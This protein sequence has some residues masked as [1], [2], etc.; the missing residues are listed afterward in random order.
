MSVNA[1]LDT[2]VWLWSLA[3]ESR[4]APSVRER[5]LADESRIWLSPVSL[6][7]ALVLADRGRVDFGMPLERWI[8][9]ATADVG[10]REAPLTFE[11]AA[12]S[13]RLRLETND[14]ADR[15]LAATARV[16][17]LT[18]VTADRRLLRSRA[19]ATLKAA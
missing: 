8:P 7:E 13:R 16:L 2:H 11:I 17:N 14:P 9:A 1:L 19:I 15:L 4:I 5:L 10:I 3:D 18:L 6:W 12:E